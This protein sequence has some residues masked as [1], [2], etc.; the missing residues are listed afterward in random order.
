MYDNVYFSYVET[1]ELRDQFFFRFLK[2]INLIKKKKKA[3]NI[4][5]RS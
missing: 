2:P 5:N 4:S 3:D 1:E